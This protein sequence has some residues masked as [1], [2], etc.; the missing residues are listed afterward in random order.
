MVLSSAIYQYP[1]WLYHYLMSKRTTQTSVT[2]LLRFQDKYLFVKRASN[3]TVDANRLNGI[4]G[5][6]EPGEDFLTCA[7]RETKEETGYEVTPKDCKFLGIVE[8]KGGYAQDWVACFFEIEVSTMEIPLGVNPDEGQFM[9]LTLEEALSSGL[10]LV[11]DLHY[12]LPYIEQEK[13]PFFMS[14]ILNDQ[15]KIAQYLL[16]SLSP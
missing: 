13:T 5:K 12:N 6:T 11:D 2:N 9:W 1:L 8:L 15:E 4:G 10:E 3:K 16:T 14:A 7:I